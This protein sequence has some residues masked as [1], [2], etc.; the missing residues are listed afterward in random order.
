MRHSSP[1]F[2]DNSGKTTEVV[3]GVG[4]A[5]VVVE[6]V[7]ESSFEVAAFFLAIYSESEVKGRKRCVA[8]Y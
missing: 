1:S 6:G 4:G 5:F 3:A 8:S 2:G 7:T